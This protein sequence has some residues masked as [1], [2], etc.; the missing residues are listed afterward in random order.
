M[1][2]RSMSARRSHYLPP[3]TQ[4]HCPCRQRRRRGKRAYR[5]FL[6]PVLLNSERL[7]PSVTEP[8]GTALSTRA[9]H[10]NPFELYHCRRLQR[11]IG[12]VALGVVP[13]CAEIQLASREI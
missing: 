7:W 13:P 5:Y 12:S 1:S 2:R 3:P 4:S 9:G 6:V 11:K 10:R 8:M